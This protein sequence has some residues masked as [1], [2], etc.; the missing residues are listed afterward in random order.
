[1]L[2]QG[3]IKSDIYTFSYV[4]QNP[5]VCQERKIKEPGIAK[6][7][8]TEITNVQTRILICANDFVR[9]Y[10]K[11]DIWTYLYVTK[12]VCLSEEKNQGSDLFNSQV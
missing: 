5:F 8:L 3:F 10:L 7:K 11:S 6:L 9:S 12:S 4:T 2:L 1:M